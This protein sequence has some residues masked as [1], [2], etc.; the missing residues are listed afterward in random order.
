[1]ARILLARPGLPWHLRTPDRLPFTGRILRIPPVPDVPEL[2]APITV[3]QEQNPI[4]CRRRAPLRAL[5]EPT[6][7]ARAAHVLL[8]AM[9]IGA[10]VQPSMAR[11]Q[12][13]GELDH[14][15]VRLR[16]DGL[17]RE[18]LSPAD[19]RQV[20]TFVFGE[21]IEGK[22][23]GKTVIKGQAELRRHD[24]VIRAD[25]IDHDQNTGDTQAQGAVR[26]QRN[27]D[28]FS[29]PR[30]EMNV[31]TD[32]GFFEQP[33]YR[34]LKNEGTG[35]ASRID[36]VDKDR[37]QVHDGRYS[38]CARPPGSASWKPDWLV[39]AKRID[40]DQAE[41]MGTAY[42]G[43][44]EFKDV[45]I[46]AAPVLSFPISDE[47][48]SGLLTP[49]AG[50]DSV[51]GTQVV[52]PYYFNLAPN[53]DLTLIPTLMSKRGLDIDGEFR[54]L[55]P[56]Y[57]GSLRVAALP[58]DKLRDDDRWYVSA[59]HRQAL[60]V[61]FG[62]MQLGLNINR[63]SD[64]NY[65]R[66]FD[67][68]ATST[69]ARLIPS[70]GEV[71]WQQGRWSMVAGAYS[72]QALQDEDNRF[73]PPYDRLPQVL[74]NYNRGDM[75]LFGSRGWNFGFASSLT[76][77]KRSIFSDD[78][79]S[80]TIDRGDRATAELSLTRRWQ[81]PG[82]FVQP[83]A[84]MRM[85]Q[86]QYNDTLGDSVSRSRAVP[87]FSADSGLIFER[88]AAYFGR[89]YVQTLEPRAFLTWTP[90]RDQSGLPNYDSGRFDLNFASMF[91]DDIY[92][93]NDR[94]GDMKALTLGVSSR[95]LDKDNGAEVVRLGLAQRYYFDDINVTLGDEAPLPKGM[96][97]MLLA[98]RIQW[99]RQWA[100]DSSIQFNHETRES[101]R[102]TIG[103]RYT[104]GDYKV[105]SAAYRVQRG[106]SEQLDLG[107]QWPLSD[108]WG[109][110]PERM[111][112]KAY[113]PGQWYSVGR[114]NYSIDERKPVEIIAG[115]EYD[116]GC[117]LARV[118][119]ER[120]Q[121]SATTRNQKIMFQLEF[122]GF[123]SLG[124][125]SLKTLGDNIPRY[126]SLRDGEIVPSRFEN[127][128]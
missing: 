49:S 112:G 4:S 26:I 38:T 5:P 41:G 13:I 50:V 1:M 43:V 37:M 116:A 9:A 102:K 71:R 82:W 117:W 17:M 95:L 84:R 22:A 25:Q 110:L 87:T 99:N 21:Q 44:L 24:T 30:L 8:A 113:G 127:Y 55:Q 90:F 56:S 40:L 125:N 45:P 120:R 115:F 97:D 18:N 86:Y 72:F 3:T 67:R 109:S 79:S 77:F 27:G 83:R 46:L 60:D 23:D 80:K 61:P 20:P 114:V 106:V 48:K 107:W 103:A 58:S 119:M 124:G 70:A 35:D 122:S 78:L 29:G 7:V 98:A 36:F 75:S 108:L 118:V 104:P 62:S 74:A 63:V 91:Y 128:D 96:S 92:G 57:G 85:A 73:T 81:A 94:I 65:W 52:A 68:I 111:R 123:A 121:T 12:L 47:R 89:D 53:Y 34:L 101:T 100:L 14:S 11:A 93:G 126:K 19:N 66:D 39:R 59:L 32:K 31:N 88:E 76:R 54:Y 2:T 15:S 33:E 6:P 28:R 10:L 105:L 42:S 64:A 69:Y 51:N 16:A